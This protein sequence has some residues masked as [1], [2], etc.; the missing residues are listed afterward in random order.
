MCGITGY[1]TLDPRRVGPIDLR[2]MNDALAPVPAAAA[3]ARAR[4]TKPPA[5]TTTSTT[6]TCL[7]HL[8]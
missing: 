4:S 7:S 8:E 1:A 5:S 2:A 3:P 6:A